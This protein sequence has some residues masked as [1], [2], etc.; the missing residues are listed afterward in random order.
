MTR[1]VQDTLLQIVKQ[2]YLYRKRSEERH[3][4]YIGELPEREGVPQEKGDGAW[5]E[6]NMDLHESLKALKGEDRE[7]VLLKWAGFTLEEL[8]QVYG[9]KLSC[10]NM[11]LRRAKEHMRKY[12]AGG[13]GRH[14][15]AW[16]PTR[17][18]STKPPVSPGGPMYGW[19]NRRVFPPCGGAGRGVARED[20][21]SAAGRYGRHL[22]PEQTRYEAGD[23]VSRP[24][25]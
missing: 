3:Q 2:Q 1:L 11:R 20:I 5:L 9:C 14:N 4:P 21:F 24:S 6:S 10:V 23:S 19:R 16:F 7:L 18:S 22:T 12:L 13:S 25:A 15:P 8:A 17:I